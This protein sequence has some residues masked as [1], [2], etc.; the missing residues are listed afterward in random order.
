MS[1]IQEQSINLE[2]IDLTDVQANILQL[3]KNNVDG[4]QNDV[5]S[6]IGQ[7]LVKFKTS[8]GIKEKGSANFDMMGELLQ[9]LWSKTV[10]II[11]NTLAQGLIENLRDIAKNSQKVEEVKSDSYEGDLAI[12]IEVDRQE[13]A[14][15]CDLL[16]IHN[17]AENKDEDTV[18]KVSDIISTSGGQLD[19]SEIAYA[20]RIGKYDGQK[21]RPIICK[22]LRR[23]SRNRVLRDQKAKMR[24]NTTFQRKYPEVFIT[25]DLTKLRQHISYHLRRDSNIDKTWSIDGRIKC[26]KKNQTEVINIDTPFDLIK[27]GWEQKRILSVLDETLTYKDNLKPTKT[28]PIQNTA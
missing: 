15:K 20:Y 5:K 27:I 6:V 19:E 9:T 7:E 26:V 22:I 25:E 1:T 11:V 23:E 16:R 3:A 17:V 12:R 2:N 28:R 14:S 10:P 8:K 13:Q 21:R 4:I 18:K 24:G